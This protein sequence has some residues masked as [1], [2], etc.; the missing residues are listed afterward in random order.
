EVADAPDLR[1]A[2]A[3]TVSAWIDPTALAP[4]SFGVVSKRV[5]Y[6]VDTEYSVFVWTDGNGVGSTNQLYIDLDTENDRVADPAATFLDAWKQITVVYDGSLGE[7]ERVRFYVDGELSYV[8]GETSPSIGAPMTEPPLYI[9]C[10][11]LSGP[12]QAFV[13]RIDEVAI[14]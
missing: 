8:A 7:A 4:A 11:P 5:D 10:L 2:G 12:A 1:A 6:Q 9:G 3:L 13:G 14:W